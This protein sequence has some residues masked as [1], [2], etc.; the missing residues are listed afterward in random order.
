[1]NKEIEI[2]LAKKNGNIEELYSQMVIERVR[3]RYSQNEENAILRK[4]LANLDY[5]NEFEAYNT[6]VE[7]C[8]Q[9]VKKE[10]GI[11]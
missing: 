6:Y 5:K 1:M 8:K 10:L 7:I 2:K 9:E 4:K 3:K 11:E